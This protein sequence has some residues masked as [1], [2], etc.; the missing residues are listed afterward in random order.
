MNLAIVILAAGKGTRM[1]SARPK[2]LHPVAGRP[3]IE[4]PVT[5][6][7]SLGAQRIVCVLGHEADAVEAAIEARFGAKAVSV[8]IQREQRGTGDAVATAMPKL[9]GFDGPVL[10][11]YGDTPLLS[12]D[13]LA[14]L[15]Q[16]AR[17]RDL[18]S[19]RALGYVK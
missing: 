5:L 4:Y 13:L 7:R 6:A 10:I 3:M 14:G 19:K 12:R 8:V 2:V 9:R 1:K 18:F 16:K 11:L 17:R 15:V